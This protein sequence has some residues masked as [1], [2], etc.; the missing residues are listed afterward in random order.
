[1]AHA[2]P[3]AELPAVALALDAQMEVA[4]VAGARP[5]PA[6][7]F[8]VGTW[9]TSLDSH[10]LLTAVHFPV[11]DGPCGFTVA[12]VALRVGDSARPGVTAGAQLAPG[13]AIQRAAIALFGMGSTPVRAAA[14]ETA[15]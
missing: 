7:D 8:F 1:L 11:W 3:A 13:G 4:T 14:A 5:V 10:E 9:T 15:L 2:D 12:E 6:A